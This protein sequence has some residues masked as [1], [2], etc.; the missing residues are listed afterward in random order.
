LPDVDLLDGLEAPR[1]KTVLRL[2][3]WV[4]AETDRGI[5]SVPA[6]AAPQGAN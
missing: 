2:P 6:N 4:A 1:A 5:V 3:D